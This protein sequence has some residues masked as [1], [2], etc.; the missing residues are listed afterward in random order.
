MNSGN[1]LEK[2]GEEVVVAC[3][4]VQTRHLP[5]MKYDTPEKSQNTRCPRRDSIRVPT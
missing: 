2:I 4:M 3:L 5:G 1:K